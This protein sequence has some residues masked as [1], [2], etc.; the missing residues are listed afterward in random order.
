MG[1]SATPPPAPDYQAQA[2]AQGAANVQAAQTTAAL[3][4]VNT[5]TP[6][7]DLTYSQPNKN[8][9]NQW[10]AA[11]TLSPD[12]QNLLTA[13]TTGQQAKA[14][15]ANNLLGNIQQSSLTPFT[16]AGIPANIDSL[17]STP[18]LSMYNGSTAAPVSQLNTSGVPALNTDWGAQAQQAQDAAYKQQ[19]ATLDPQ[20]AQLQEQEEAKLAASGATQGS[21]AYSN[22]MDDFDRQRGSD[23]ANAR[24][25]SIGI[26]NNEQATLAGESL[27]GNNQLY[28]QAL[29]GAQFANTAAGQT[30]NQGITE[31]NTNNT[32]AQQN[33]A[34]TQAADTFANNARATDLSQGAMLQQLPLN[35]YNALISG[36]Q[37]T[38]PNF[39]V[40]TAQTGPVGAAPVFAAAQAQQGSLNDIYNAQQSADNSNTQAGLGAAGLAT[41]AAIAF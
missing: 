21:Q 32:V 1:K 8:D 20:Y 13:Q 29:S 4:R 38:N 18:D 2:Q 33:F 26:G 22:A 34:N 25:S 23:Y 12:Q 40:G 7:G 37:V 14:D 15:D 9:P 36:S 6:Y 39:N 11:V 28:G 5:Q 31:N 24:T 17:G 10:N 16:G 35:E 3:N 30:F 27:A 19:T 41:A